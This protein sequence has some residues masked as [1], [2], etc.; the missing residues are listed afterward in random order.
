[1]IVE[2]EKSID[3]LFMRYWLHTMLVVVPICDSIWCGVHIRSAAD[4]M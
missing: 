3:A 1:M 4:R 2:I